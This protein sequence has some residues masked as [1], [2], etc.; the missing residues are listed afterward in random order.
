MERVPQ[1]GME[2]APQGG[3]MEREIEKNVTPVFL[4]FG[5]IGRFSDARST[6]GLWNALHRACPVSPGGYTPLC[7]PLGEDTPL[8][9]IF[10]RF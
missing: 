1:G 8:K 7:S 10:S 4:V 3:G 2:R 6:G 9:S 5:R